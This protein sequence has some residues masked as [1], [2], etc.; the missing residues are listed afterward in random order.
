MYYVEVTGPG[1]NSL[2]RDASAIITESHVLRVQ[3]SKTNLYYINVLRCVL[4]MLLATVEPRNKEFS[5]GMYI[6]RL[7]LRMLNFARERLCL[8]PELSDVV[9]LFRSFACVSWNDE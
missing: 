4:S 1:E 5:N 8:S 3:P 9:L 7:P 6:H 2:L